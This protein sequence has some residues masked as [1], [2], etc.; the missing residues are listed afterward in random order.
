VSFSSRPDRV[1][2]AIIAVFALLRLVCAAMVGLSFDEAYTVSVAHS[3]N[4]SYYD[5]P[6][7]QYWIEHLFLPL[8][9]D[10]R[11]ARLPFIALFAGTSWLLYRLTERLFDARAGVLAVLAL[12]C[13]GC[14]TFG[15]GTMVEPDG[16]LMFAM[17][18]AAL[19]LTRVLFPAR[20]NESGELLVWLQGGLWI[21]LA[22]L[23]KYHA[24]LFA[25]GLLLFLLSVPQQRRRLNRSAP[26]LAALL[27]IAIASP[28][29]VWNLRHHWASFEFQGDR[30]LPGGFHPGYVLANIAGQA[31]WLLP[32]IFVPLLIAAT[33][34]LRAGPAAERTW[35][36]LCLGLPTVVV[37]T[38]IPLWGG[39]IGLP[40]WQMP[41]WLMLF[42]LLGE[43][44]SR[45]IEGARLRRFGIAGA[46][47]MPLFA[48]AI[49][50]QVN[51]GYARIAAPSG[52]PFV[53]PTLEMLSWR[54]LPPQLTA[55]GLLP[56]GTFVI[57]TSWFYAGKIDQALNGSVP[58]VVFNNDPREYGLRDGRQD[59]LGHDA[60][61]VAPVSAMRGVADGLRPYFDSIEE[62]RAPLALGRLG[63]SEIE[64]TVLRA[65]RLRTPLPA[66]A[67][68]R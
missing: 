34:A 40:H 68:A 47:A 16:P 45:A 4:L 42:P 3:L 38:L 32:W 24:A 49:V 41:G 66:P 18:A 65:Q 5:H 60:I 39:H 64:L 52:S 43:W 56:T 6:P 2:L 58:V 7:L 9:G 51:T 17:L 62:E 36:C 27:V 29:F 31:I 33:R 61:V 14:F 10:G 35:Y 46:I 44:A 50:F 28:V 19:T 59:L 57:T 55:R 53:D 8:L 11:A 30:A 25:A 22:A 37:F 15:L 12:N 63:R 13:S 67:W 23:S 20:E 48:I 26:W 1:A 54:Q 21:G